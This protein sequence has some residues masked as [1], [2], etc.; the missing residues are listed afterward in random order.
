ML[1]FFNWFFQGKQKVQRVSTLYASKFVEIAFLL[2]LSSSWLALYLVLVVSWD[3]WKFSTISALLRNFKPQKSC[4]IR[5]PWSCKFYAIFCTFCKSVDI[6]VLLRF[7]WFCQGKQ[8]VRHV[9]T[10][11]SSKFMEVVFLVVPVVVVV[12]RFANL[13]LLVSWDVGKYLWISA[14]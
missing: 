9:F 12:I 13:V 3:V 4:S 1:S 11:Y 8:K 5:P 10:L 14:L 7:N 6:V 2:W